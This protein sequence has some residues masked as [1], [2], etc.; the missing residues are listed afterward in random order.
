MLPHIFFDLVFRGLSDWMENGL[1]VNPLENVWI[2]DDV[3]V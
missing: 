1:S 3:F 2:G